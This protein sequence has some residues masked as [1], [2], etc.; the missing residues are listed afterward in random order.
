MVKHMA[1]DEKMVTNRPVWSVTG[2]MFKDC[3]DNNLGNW[4]SWSCHSD[5]LL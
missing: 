1:K 2:I 3:L 4:D 5:I